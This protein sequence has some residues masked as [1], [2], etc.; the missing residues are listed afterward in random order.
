MP[1]KTSMILLIITI[2]SILIIPVYGQ[3]ATYIL[4]SPINLP[5]EEE[6][7]VYNL[8]YWISDAATYGYHH[9]D[10]VFINSKATRNAIYNAAGTS[11]EPTHVFFLGHG[12]Y[13]YDNNHINLF[14]VDYNDNNVFDYDIYPH[15]ST[16]HVHLAFLYSCYQGRI[17]GEVYSDCYC[18][19]FIGCWCNTVQSG[20]AQAWLHTT[21]LSDDGYLYPDD[22]NYVFI[23]WYGPAPYLSDDINGDEDA[24]YRFTG[25]F[26]T[27][28][29][30]YYTSE[31]YSVDGALDYASYKVT[32]DIFYFSYFYNGFAYD[33]EQ[34][35][36][37][38]Y[39]DGNYDSW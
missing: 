20:Q 9:V 11:Y 14:I 17:I 6:T 25:Y 28:L 4:A 13:A 8:L 21:D 22:K 24:G 36:I 12:S 5:S 39:G 26:F 16:R 29:Y 30:G 15:S 27:K 37:V 7:Y 2:A 32:G 1:T 18:F 35:R 31:A 33:S 23:G 38:V 19:P 10:N 34:T 3:S